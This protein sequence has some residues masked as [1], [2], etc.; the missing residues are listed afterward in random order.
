MMSDAYGNQAA[1]A[2]ENPNEEDARNSFQQRLR[3][4]SLNRLRGRI[5]NIIA[6]INKPLADVVRDH[7]LLY[8]P[9]ASLFRFLSVHPSWRQVISSA[10][11]AHTHSRTHLYRLSGVFAGNDTFTP[12]LTFLS[13]DPKADDIPHPALS[14]LPDRPISVRCSSN[15]LICCFAWTT[16]AYFVCNPATSDWVRIPTPPNYPGPNPPLALIFEPSAYNFRSDFALVCAVESCTGSGVYGFQT[17][18]SATGQWWVSDAVAPAEGLIALSGISA[19]G[20]AYWRTAI[21]TVVGYDPPAD[22]ARVMTC[23]PMAADMKWELG[24]AAGALCCVAATESAVMAYELGRGDEWTQV[25]FASVGPF[26]GD[27]EGIVIRYR[28]WPLRFQCAKLEAALWAG[29]SVIAVDFAGQRTRAIGC[30]GPDPS[31]M[32]YVAHINTL[33]PVVKTVE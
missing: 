30:V 31:I 32:E 21:G 7:V 25:G 11:F 16:N 6:A 8:L 17:F 10:L 28:P 18:S 26:G 1:A 13:F 19:G 29:G 12:G 14:F 24:A 20:A 2:V 15:G 9:P 4:A 3:W 27:E 5:A 33:A 23:P 22:R